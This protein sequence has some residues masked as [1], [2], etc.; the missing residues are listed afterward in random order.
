MKKPRSREII[1]ILADVI[2][3]AAQGCVVSIPNHKGEFNNIENPMLHYVFG[4]SLYVK[5]NLD[6]LSRTPQGNIKKLPMVALFTPFREQRNMSDYFSKAKVNILIACST[7]Q[8]WNNEQRRIYS[9]ENILRPIYRRFLEALQEDGRFDFGYDE[10][11]AHEYSENYSYGKYGA[12]DSSGEAVS[13]PIDAI[14]ITNLE[15]KVKLP[16]CRIQ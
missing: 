15:L 6:E 9:F 13:E 8:D 2:K 4:N 11:I 1:E 5:A 14:N 16:N 10:V 7:R 12:R 3:E